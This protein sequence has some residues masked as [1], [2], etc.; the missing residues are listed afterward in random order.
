MRLKVIDGPIV[1][2]TERGVLL[3]NKI[4]KSNKNDI[5]FNDGF[6]VANVIYIDEYVALIGVFNGKEPMGKPD[7][8]IYYEF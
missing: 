1:I 2:E 4:I 5:V 3:S 6:V 7:S 8:Y